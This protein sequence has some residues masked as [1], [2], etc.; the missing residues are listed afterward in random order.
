MILLVFYFFL[1]P[2]S[3]IHCCTIGM[4]DVIPRMNMLNGSISLR[5][6]WMIII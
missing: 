3:R 5:N 4:Q 1:W 6:I 2:L